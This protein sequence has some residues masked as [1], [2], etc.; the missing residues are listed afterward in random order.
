[1]NKQ[2]ILFINQI[3]PTAQPVK[4]KDDGP[5]AKLLEPTRLLKARSSRASLNQR[6][7]TTVG[8]A[9]IDVLKKGKHIGL[10]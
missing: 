1:M 9:N 4:R 3:L 5:S 8:S 6:A 7:M 2:F 10:S